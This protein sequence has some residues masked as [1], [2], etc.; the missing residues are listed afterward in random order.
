MSSHESLQL[1]FQAAQAVGA[2]ATAVLVLLA[3]LQIKAVKEQV[4]LAREQARTTFENS[5]TEQYRAIIRDIPIDIWLK[6]ELKELSPEQ[7]N[8]C[9]DAIYRYIELSQEEAFLYEN[10]RVSHEAWI[11]WSDGIKGNMALPA[12]RDVWALVDKGRPESFN[13][14]RALLP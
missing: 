1:A 13:E 9:R 11:Q 5:L 3:W 12:F 10:K 4:K 2:I 7:Q 14:F 6:A 8:R